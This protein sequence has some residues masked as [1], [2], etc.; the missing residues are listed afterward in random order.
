[1]TY[2]RILLRLGDPKSLASIVLYYTKYLGPVQDRLISIRPMTMFDDTTTH[3]T[4]R[5]Y[6]KAMAS[7]VIEVAC[8]PAPRRAHE[9]LR[10]LRMSPQS[11][12]RSI[13]AWSVVRLLFCLL[14]IAG[15]ASALALPGAQARARSQAQLDPSQLAVAAPASSSRVSPLVYRTDLQPLTS[16]DGHP[17]V[18][19][20]AVLGAKRVMVLRVYFNDYTAT[21]HYTTAQVQGFF[22]QLDQLWRNT[23]YNKININYQVSDLFKLPDNRSAYV[24]DHSDGDLSDGSQ[25]GKVLLDSIANAPA[26]LD[27]SNLDAIMVVMAETDTT[28]FHRG[29]GTGDRNLPQGPGG[30]VKHL[31]CA[32][33]SENAG[34]PN[35]VA[36]WGRW[37]HEI[38]HAFQQAGPAHPS[39]YNNSFELMDRSYPGQTGIFEKQ[40]DQGFPG[41]MPETKYVNF[42]PSPAPPWA[43]AGAGVGGGL[44]DLRSEELDPSGFPNVQAARVYITNNLYYLVSVRRKIL[45]DDLRPIPD[46]GILIERVMVGG[47]PALNDCA[48]SGTCPRIVEVKGPG[49]DA[50]KLWQANPNLPFVGD[51]VVITIVKPAT[52]GADDWEVRISYDSK[53]QPDV[54]I[55]PWR[56]PPGNAWESTDIWVDSPVNGYGSY[57]YGSWASNFGDIVPRGNGDDPTVGQANRV[58]A[59]V[60]NI[61]TTNAIDVHVH[62]DRT[63][64]EGKGINGA[65]GFIEMTPLGGLTSAQFPAL[66]SIP[67]G[68]YVDV[69]VNYT[70]SFTPTP[71]QLAAGTFYFH[72]CLRVRIDPVAGETVLGNQD[73]IDEQE[74]IDYFQ[75][76]QPSSPSAPQYTDFIKLHNDDTLNP[77]FFQLS[78]TSNLPPSWDLSV[79]GGNLGVQLA[80]NE[81]RDLPIVITPHG[82]GPDPAPGTTYAVEVLAQFQRDML[83]STDPTLSPLEKKHFEFKP[84]GGVR[85]EAKVMLPTKISCEAQRGLAVTGAPIINVKGRLEGIDKYDPRNPPRVMIEGVSTAAGKPFGYLQSSLRTVPV[86]QY[87]QFAGTLGSDQFPPTGVICLFGGTDTLASAWAGPVPIADAPAPSTGTV[88]PTTGGGLTI[89]G[90]L[91]ILFPA[92]A[93]GSQLN[94]FY[95]PIFSPTH[96]LPDAA[97]LDA[98]DLTAQSNGQDVTKFDKPYTLVIDYDGA[99]ARQLGLNLARLNLVYW[100]GS[101]WV[102]MLPCP[103]CGIDAANN[104]ITIV[105]DHFTEFALIGAADRRLYLPIVRR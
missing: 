36:V 4:T 13:L 50:N 102:P 32:I 24:T 63:D 73:G 42:V 89:P 86:N 39:N 43:P 34:L 97:L 19:M 17:L 103:G 38:G 88:S 21:S 79:N 1:M 22:A 93:Y 40:N 104:R 18:P 101:A 92:G 45:G 94:L 87:G 28:Q 60:R 56:S 64:P 83:N 53:P 99:L 20:G 75:A 65:N 71:E 11:T 55:S 80:A 77:K 68:G 10:R 78:Y 76:V 100:N 14:L 67:P 105:A 62:I 82:P 15:A 84:L 7:I 54:M 49:G 9:L 5:P 2:I 31:G 69:F 91:S 72:T 27:W 70:P 6:A 25:F 33:F 3:R 96:Q 8:C 26:G 81:I 51:G 95:T 30:S 59:R 41:W 16:P 90:K 61:G 12:R 57:R 85:I 46:E 37:A 58:Y 74:N 48:P 35:D 98:F 47:N 66:A 23:S 52:F 29:Q 44:A